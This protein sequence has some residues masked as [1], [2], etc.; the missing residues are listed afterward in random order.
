MTSVEVSVIPSLSPT[1]SRT[2]LDPNAVSPPPDD[3]AVLTRRLAAGDEAAFREFHARYF[4]RLYYFLLVVTHGQE[5]EAQEALQDT[6]LR[7]GHAHGSP[8]AVSPRFDR[9]VGQGESH[10]R[11]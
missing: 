5:L 4:D 6:L 1:P 11:R 9:H 3:T 10:H 7:S 2:V 8:H